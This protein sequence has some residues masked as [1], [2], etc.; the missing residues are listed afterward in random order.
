MTEN[1]SAH[2]PGQVRH[3]GV[4]Q[5]I[6]VIGA[7]LAGLTAAGVLADRGCQVTVLEKA[8]GP[9]GRMSTRR[10]GDLRFDH[11]AQYFTA[12]HPR[13]MAQ[14]ESWRE[15]GLV[16]RWDARI[17]VVESDTIRAAGTGTERYVGVPGMN[18]VCRHLA[19]PQADC[20]FG[21]QVTRARVVHDGWVLE[22]SG[23][24]RLEADYLLLTGPPE[25]SRALVAQPSVHE[26]LAPVAMRPCWAVMALFDRPLLEDWDAAFVNTGA[27]SWI[28]SQASKPDRPAAHAWTL[29][30]GP[31]WSRDHLEDD[32]ERVAEVLL[33]EATRLRGAA[34][35]TARSVRAHRWR[36]ALAREPLERGAFWFPDIRLAVAGDWCAGSRIEGAFLSGLEAGRRIAAD[37]AG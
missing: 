16:R 13:F 29:H 19:K 31:D 11:G 6:A 36:Y 7:G 4:R 1:S 17:A 22:S 23:G 9:G 3:S 35:V 33:A 28:A 20:R 24:D 5:R 32:S 26:A 34:A 21:W 10:D 14:V 27:L 2:G 25:Q 15:A 8:R 12:R 37:L 18:A 30:A